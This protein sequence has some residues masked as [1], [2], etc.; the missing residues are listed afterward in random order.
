MDLSDS[1]G[2]VNFNYD[3]KL[4]WQTNTLYIADQSNSV[5]WSKI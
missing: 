4:E 1:Q 5:A 3:R 2:L